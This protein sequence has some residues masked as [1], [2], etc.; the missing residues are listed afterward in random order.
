M[1]SL[2]WK[3]MK[4]V[5]INKFD[6]SWCRIKMISSRWLTWWWGSPSPRGSSP[7]RPSAPRRWWRRSGPCRPTRR[8][9]ASGRP[10]SP[11]AGR[12][13][14]RAGTTWEP[15]VVRRGRWSRC[16]RAQDKTRYETVL[17]FQSRY[18]QVYTLVWRFQ[19]IL[20]PF[21]LSFTRLNQAKVTFSLR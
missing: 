4:S 14:S 7:A 15:F 18:R 12:W 6:F 2:G 13:R 1:L 11:P 21:L 3:R 10:A 19:H 16:L 5:L 9:P 17:M 20:L 8:A